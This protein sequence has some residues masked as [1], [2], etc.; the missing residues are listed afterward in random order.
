ML[1]PAVLW[2]DCSSCS[3]GTQLKGIRLLVVGRRR[4][5]EKLGLSARWCGLEDGE[6]NGLYI[7]VLENST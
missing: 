3:V 7:Q 6:S 5:S 4:G 2:E 1:G